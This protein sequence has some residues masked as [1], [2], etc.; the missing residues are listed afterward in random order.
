MRKIWVTAIALIS[1]LLVGTSL[2]RELIDGNECRVEPDEIVSGSLFAL[3]EQLVIE[4]EVQGNVLGGALSTT[5]TGNVTGSVYLVSFD[6]DVSGTIQRDLH[7]AGANL[8]I[9][10][11]ETAL[12]DDNLGEEEQPYQS[13][14]NGNLLTASLSTTLGDHVTVPGNI[15][16]LGY[17]LI[18]DGDVED[19]INFWGS[20]LVIDGKIND[21]VYAT[22]GNPESDAAQLEALLL[23]L[24]EPITF[25]NTLVNPGLTITENGRVDGTLTYTGPARAQITGEVEGRIDYTEIIPLSQLPATV[26]PGVLSTY[27]DGVFREFTTLVVVGIIG[28]VFVPRFLMTPILHLRTRPISSLTVGMLSFILSF[29]IFLIVIF[30]SLVIL[31]IIS[32]FG[33]DGVLIVA[34]VVLATVNFT[35]MSLFYLLAI[36][37]A[38]VIV[39]LALGRFIIRLTLGSNQGVRMQYI[40]M[41]VGT[42]LVA[43]LASIPGLGWIFNAVTLFLGLGAV[44]TVLIE[45]MGQVRDSSFAGEW[46]IAPPISRVQSPLKQ[47]LEQSK[48]TALP[49]PP[50]PEEPPPLGMSN[51]P[52][53]FDPDFFKED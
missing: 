15:T 31:L 42:L 33:L 47:Q 45:Y 19:E 16:Q 12:E 10:L 14:L 49:I 46:S 43:L 38:R 35:G 27:F 13:P 25:N 52:A 7:F 53:G 37:V 40:C 48:Q 26:E 21:S 36:M 8:N 11:P 20:S 17:Q 23:L 22:V 34:T 4:G 29:P 3:C 2:A 18:I 44:L 6:M 39:A 41:G 32:L 1:L 28:L 5:I 24:P 50:L 30:L 51:L 9:A